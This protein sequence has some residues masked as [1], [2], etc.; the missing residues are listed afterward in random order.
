ME[1][2]YL[3]LVNEIINNGTVVDD[4]TGTGTRAIFG[5]VMKC[6]LQKEFPLLTTKFVNFNTIADELLWFISGSTDEKKLNSRIWNKNAQACGGELGPIYGFQW[7]HWGATYNTCLDDYTGQGID[8]LAKVIDLLKNDPKSRRILLSSWNV[9]DLPRMALEPCHCF[10]QFDT[11]DGRLNCLLFQRSGDMGLGVPFN[12][13]SYALLTIMIAH[14][15]N[16]VPGQFTHVLG[17]AHIYLDHEAGLKKQLERKPFN[18]PNIEIVKNITN[19]D[20]FTMD[21]FKLN[22]Y[23]HHDGIKLN[24]SV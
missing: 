17:N 9:A 22:N 12:M 19:I 8:Q 21:C 16:M 10:V 3:N 13:A 15:I 18:P 2:E 20:D 6:D 5:A 1:Q 23:Q 24:M 7:R 14:V 11:S 4:R